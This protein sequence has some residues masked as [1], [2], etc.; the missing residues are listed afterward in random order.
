[1]RPFSAVVML[2][3]ERWSRR[4]SISRFMESSSTTR[5]LP[6]YRALALPRNSTGDAGLL[7]GTGGPG[8]A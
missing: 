7:A 1:M 3:P 4:A 5:R 8:A 6:V 2:K